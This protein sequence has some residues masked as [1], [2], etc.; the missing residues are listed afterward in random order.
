MFLSILIALLILAA[1][2]GLRPGLAAGARIEWK[3]TRLGKPFSDPVVAPNGLMYFITGKNLLALDTGGKQILN[4]KSPADSGDPR[5]VFLPNG[6]ILLAGQSSVQEIKANGGSGWR[7][8]IT[9]GKKQARSNPLLTSGP[10]NLLYLPLPTGLYAVDTNGNYRWKMTWEESESR[11]PLID[12]KREILACA[13]DE[14]YL[15]TVYGSKDAGYTLAAVDAAGDRAWR[16]SLGSI[17]EAGLATDLEG[18]LCVTAN[19]AKAAKGQSAGRLYFFESGSGGDPAWIYSTLYNDLT[20]PGFSNDG[21]VYFCAG[22]CLFA[23]NASSGKEIW[24]DKLYK[25]ATRPFVDNATGIIYLGTD[26]NRLLAVGS[27]GRLMWGM[28]LEGNITVQPLNTS[29]GKLYVATDKG[30]LYM[31]TG[32]SP[33]GD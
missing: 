1:P 10:D 33:G 27:Q 32:T 23:I 11:N 17:K 28:E 4:I 8:S 18:N 24:R 29:D 2:V 13:A 31:I 21:R 30:V 15:Y 7:I 26:D 19:T 12:T 5:P 6:S 14:Q 9:D 16:Y 20:A 3:L 22:E 25:A